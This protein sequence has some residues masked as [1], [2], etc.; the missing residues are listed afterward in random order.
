HPDRNPGDKACEEKFKE[1]GNLFKGIGGKINDEIKAGDGWYD[2][3]KKQAFSLR[4]SLALKIL[5]K[6]LE[7]GI[8]QLDEAKASIDDARKEDSSIKSVDQIK[9]ELQDD[10][11]ALES[12]LSAA[13]DAGDENAFQNVLGDFRVKW[14]TIRRDMEKAASQAVGKACTVALAQFQCAKPKIDVGFKQIDDLRAKC[15]AS[16]TD[17]CLKVNEFSP[18]FNTISGKFGDL[19]SEMGLAEKM[20]QTPETA[21]RKNLIALMKKI[22][23]DAEDLKLYGQALEAEKQKAIAESAQQ[24][25]SQVLPQLDAAK[26]ELAKNDIVVLK[27]KIGKCAGSTSEECKIVNQITPQFRKFDS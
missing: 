23:A 11:R 21:D 24:I 10:R 19:K 25:C 12:K 27:N 18:R 13:L 15:A 7:D 4:K 2:Q 6:N 17:E 26:T 5:D 22:Q 9:S 1:I 8:K 14:E 20:C 3:Y 16:A